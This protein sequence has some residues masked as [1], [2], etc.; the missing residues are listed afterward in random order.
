MRDLNT[1][2]RVRL[3]DET[4]AGV[5]PTGAQRIGGLLRTRADAGMAVL[6]ADHRVSEALSFCDRVVLLLDGR[7]EVTCGPAEFLEHPAVRRRYLG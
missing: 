2:P 6:V 4:L 7:V 5:D 3:C 1:D